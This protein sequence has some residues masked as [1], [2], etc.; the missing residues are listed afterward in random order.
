MWE[1][2]SRP[3]NANIFFEVYGFSYTKRTLMALL[4]DIRLGYW[5]MMPVNNMASI[6]MIFLA[7][8]SNLPLFLIF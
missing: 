6:V 2:V 1:L 4:R 8:L 3:T 7:P 5:V